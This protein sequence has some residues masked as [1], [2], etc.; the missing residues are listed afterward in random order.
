[1][2]QRN[3]RSTLGIIV[4]MTVPLFLLASTGCEENGPTDAVSADVTLSQAM[5]TADDQP[6]DGQTMHQG[7]AGT[8]RYEARLVDRHGEPAPGYQVR[9]RVSMPSMMGSMHP[10]SEELFCYDDGTHGDPVPGDG[11]YCFEDTGHEHGCHQIDAR[12]GEYHYDFCGVDD[13]G[14]ES[15][16]MHLMVRLLP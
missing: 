3:T 1:M 10:M 9:V 8:M 11:V 2:R 14:Y 12:P 15:N 5:I 4:A 6:L 16:H 13:H 7:E